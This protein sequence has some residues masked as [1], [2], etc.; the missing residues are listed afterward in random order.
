MNGSVMHQM[1]ISEDEWTRWNEKLQRAASTFESSQTGSRDLSLMFGDF[2]KISGLVLDVGSGPKKAPYLEAAQC[3]RCVGL[4]PLPI[5]EHGFDLV[6]GVGEFLPFRDGAFDHCI[7]GTSLDHCVRPDMTLKEMRRVTK[8]EGK[9]NLWIGTFDRPIEKTSTTSC[10]S[11]DARE[12]WD[13]VKRRN[14]RFL[15]KAVL[16][17]ISRKARRT[18]S[19]TMDRLGIVSDPYHL[20]RFHDKDI[21]RLLAKTGMSVKDWRKLQDG[22]LFLSVQ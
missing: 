10:L 5:K 1:Q 20:Y 11:Q 2:C 6:C 15:T 18:T 3:K 22:S 12:A 16:V 8:R 19:W 4:D 14:F 7:C 17:R 13:V 9:I 21:S